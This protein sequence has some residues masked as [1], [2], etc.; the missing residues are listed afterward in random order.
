M[1]VAQ[2]T[3]RLAILVIL[4]SHLGLVSLVGLQ[5]NLV[6]VQVTATEPFNLRSEA[7]HA[8][9]EQKLAV[10]QAEAAAAAKKAATFRVSLHR[11][12]RYC[13]KNAHHPS[14]MIACMLARPMDVL[15]A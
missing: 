2:S 11:C 15:T 13:R 1:C 12:C 14:D 3:P 6:D 7:R 4:L 5:A 9:A 8:A 10:R